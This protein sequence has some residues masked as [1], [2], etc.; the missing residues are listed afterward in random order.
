MT[1]N[2]PV[3]YPYHRTSSSRWRCSEA[4]NSVPLFPNMLI[5]SEVYIDSKMTAS[6][7]YNILCFPNCEMFHD[8]KLTQFLHFTTCIPI[9]HIV[10]WLKTDSVSKFSSMLPR[11]YVLWQQTDSFYIFRV[12]LSW[13]VPW[14]K[15]GW[16]STFSNMLPRFEVLRDR[17][18]SHFLIF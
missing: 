18:L 8:K 13:S 1:A 17:K 2:W 14:R 11:C 3:L 5:R 9:I 15:T 12:F 4:A 7:F 10:S 6:P 16:V